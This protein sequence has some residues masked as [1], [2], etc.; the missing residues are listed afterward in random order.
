MDMDYVIN[1]FTELPEK[2]QGGFMKKLGGNT[3]QQLK[4]LLT[5]YSDFSTRMKLASLLAKMKNTK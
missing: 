2:E 5:Q 4:E 3:Q 1:F